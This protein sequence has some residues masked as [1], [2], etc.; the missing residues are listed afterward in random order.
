[1]KM[2]EYKKLMEY[3]N[4]NELDLELYIDTDK[5]IVIVFKKCSN[6]EFASYEYH[7]RLRQS[8]YYSLINRNA[9]DTYLLENIRKMMNKHAEND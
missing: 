2:S 9:L 4:D 1:M 3:C 8:V 6:F 5:W 7:I